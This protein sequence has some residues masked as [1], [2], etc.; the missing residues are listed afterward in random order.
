MNESFR[1][2]FASVALGTIVAFSDGTPRPPERHN[3]KLSDWKNRNGTGRLVCKRASEGVKSWDKDRITLNTGNYGGDG[4]I[5]V[6]VNSIFSCDSALTFE[7]VQYE[8]EGRFALLTHSV[9]VGTEYKGS[10]PT[11]EAA[12]A[13]IERG[14]RYS[15][16]EICRVGKEGELLTLELA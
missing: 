13:E 14:Y 8:A 5:A 11:L 16:T 2:I 1:R 15:E 6:V 12:Q 10:F 4:F 7:P 9:H 3:K